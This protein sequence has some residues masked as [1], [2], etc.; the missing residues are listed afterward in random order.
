MDYKLI[1]EQLH[2]TPIHYVMGNTDLTDRY[3][4]NLA[5][6]TKLAEQNVIPNGEKFYLRVSKDGFFNDLE[7]L[8]K[9]IPLNTNGLA[10]S[11]GK[12][13]IEKDGEEHCPAFPVIIKN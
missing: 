2:L 1:Q 9:F 11:L 3:Y 4:R 8:S 10:L 6:N 5:D 7:K 12:S 13:V